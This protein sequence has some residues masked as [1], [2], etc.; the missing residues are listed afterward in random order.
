MSLIENSTSHEDVHENQDAEIT[1]LVVTSKLNTNNSELITSE[2]IDNTE[3]PSQGIVYKINC[4]ANHN[5]VEW[6]EV[7]G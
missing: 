3:V 6:L 4:N 1:P 2:N 5:Y 7:L